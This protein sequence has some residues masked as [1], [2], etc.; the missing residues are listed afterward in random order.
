VLKDFIL[1]IFEER[2]SDQKARSAIYERYSNPLV[3]SAISLLNRC[4]EILCQEHR[5]VYLR[6][7]G[8]NSSPS[9]GG[10]FR[11]YKKLSTVY[12]L[13]TVL[14]WIRACRREFS[15]L[16][17]AEPGDA[18][19][20]DEA[21]NDFENALADGNWVEQERVVRLCELWHLCTS[22]KLQ[23][24]QRIEALG[25]QVDNLIWDHLGLANLDDVSLLNEESQR[26]LCRTIADCLSSHLR[27]N[28]VGDASMDRSWPDAFSIIGMREAWLYRDWQSAI[29]D[30]M[31][32]P[33]QSDTRKFDVMGYGDFEQILSVGSEKQKLVL[34]RLLAIFDN[35]DFSIE[36]RFD[37]RPR[38]LRSIAK[39]NAKLILAFHGIKG[40]Q[41]IVSVRDIERANTIIRM[42]TNQSSFAL[43]VP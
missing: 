31:I 35:L 33:S 38:Q 7:A 20:V 39:A 21:I 9:Q 28:V 40:K 23:G 17:V 26:A 30:V 8:I 12:R 18:I 2:R 19:S 34:A 42:S 43:E 10:E 41:S 13:A 4:H 37:A 27:T 25:V 29:G 15:Y 11:S 14:G 5:P 22:E 16:R 3:T 36:D 24:D 1:K 32:Q 6:G